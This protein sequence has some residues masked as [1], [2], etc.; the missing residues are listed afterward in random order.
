MTNKYTLF[1]ILLSTL[2]NYG[3]TLS[4]KVIDTQTN[5]PLETVSIYFDNTTIGTTTN[6]NGEF[7]INYSDAI[8][9][10]LVI[11]LLGYETVYISDYRTKNTISIFLKESISELDEVI[12]DADDGMARAEKLRWFR[13]EFLGTSAFGKSC[14]IQNEND[15][16]F[17]YNKRTRTLIAWSKVP[18]VVNNKSLQY[19]VG[20]DI[21]DFEIVIG[22]WRAKSVIYAG[23]TFFKDLDPKQKRRTIKNRESAYQGSIQHFMRALY[24][25]TFDEDGFTFG[26]KGFKVVPYDYFT[27]YDTDKLGYKTVTLKQKLDIYYKDQGSIIQTTVDAFKVDKYG[28]Y[29]P[30]QDVLFGGNLGAQRLGEL[31][32]IDFKADE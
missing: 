10:N 9:S 13:K 6:K 12:I 25:K 23:T 14:K 29:A 22:T 28:N 1:F 7:S 26:V 8:Q 32:P 4:G 31:L 19:Q 5:S 20:F 30:I 18:I 17:R 24:H 21:I 3:Q 2:L 27:I 16:K 11:S 15:L